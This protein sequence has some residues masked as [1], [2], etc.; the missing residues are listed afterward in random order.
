MGK[1]HDYPLAPYVHSSASGSN[2]SKGRSKRPEIVVVGTIF[3][4]FL[5]G[6]SGYSVVDANKKADLALGKCFANKLGAVGI[7]DRRQHSDPVGGDPSYR[8]TFASGIRSIYNLSELTPIPCPP[9][10]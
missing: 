6:Y 8:I 10:R 2:A 7:A 9:A 3:V 5:I 1:E 4:A